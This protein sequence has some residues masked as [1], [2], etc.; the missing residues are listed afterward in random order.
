MSAELLRHQAAQL[1]RALEA[2][3]QVEEGCAATLR[4]T[5][6]PRPYV[7]RR[8]LRAAR[9]RAALKLIAQARGLL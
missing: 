2:E 1:Q 3:A 4:E 9:L 6:Y 7:E 5:N 8:E